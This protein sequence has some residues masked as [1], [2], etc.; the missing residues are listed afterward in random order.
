VK[1]DVLPVRIPVEE[2]PVR[3]LLTGEDEDARV[4]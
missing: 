1:K 2:S 4:K 3:I